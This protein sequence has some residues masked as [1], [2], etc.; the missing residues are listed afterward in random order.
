MI[1]KNLNADK[2][3]VCTACRKTIE[4]REKYFTLP[5]SFQRYCLQ[6]APKEIQ[7]LVEL[8]NKDLATLQNP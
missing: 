3:P 7:K 8:L 2:P 4:Y 5:S 1:I 6:C